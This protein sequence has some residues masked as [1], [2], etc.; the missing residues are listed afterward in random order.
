M[1]A[2]RVVSSDNMSRLHKHEGIASIGN[3]P[4]GGSRLIFRNKSWAH[5]N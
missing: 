3:L 4:E 1:A 5:R 2:A